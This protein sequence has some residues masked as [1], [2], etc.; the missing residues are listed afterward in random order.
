M[1]N[2]VSSDA[3][4]LACQNNDVANLKKQLK[5]KVNVNIENGFGSTGLHTACAYGNKD[6]VSL[7]LANNVDV[8]KVR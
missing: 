6:I 1:G 2:S 7:L 5:L 4:L 3:F 8:N